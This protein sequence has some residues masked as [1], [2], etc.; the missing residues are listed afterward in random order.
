MLLFEWD[1][2]KAIINL[3]RH[4]ISIDEACTAFRDPL[5]LTIDDPLHTEDENRFILMGLSHKKRMLVVVHTER[6]N[7]IRIICARKMTKQ[8]RK[9]HESNAQ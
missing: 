2:K 6:G 1:P 9:Y 4:G 8:E 3:E 5:S 7:K